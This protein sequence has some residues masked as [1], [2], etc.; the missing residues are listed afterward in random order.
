MEETV[1]LQRV[2]RKGL[3]NAIQRSSVI[4]VYI[5]DDQVHIEM[6]RPGFLSWPE[7]HIISRFLCTI[8]YWQANNSLMPASSQQSLPIT[9]H[10]SR[11]TA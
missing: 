7:S 11:F 6:L 8:L 10:H 1:T 2:D 9:P 5:F 3:V 4:A